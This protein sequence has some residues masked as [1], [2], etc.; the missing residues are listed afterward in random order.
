MRLSMVFRILCP[1]LSQRGILT[2]TVFCGVVRMIGYAVAIVLVAFYVYSSWSG[3]SPGSDILAVAGLCVV[4]NIVLDA[5]DT[6]IR[7]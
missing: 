5:L 4:V 1:F 6:A 7:R 3:D 2:S